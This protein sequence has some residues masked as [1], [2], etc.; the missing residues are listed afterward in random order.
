M[1]VAMQAAFAA[2]VWS[3]IGLAMVL[4]F[5]AIA[6]IRRGGPPF[7]GMRCAV[8]MA[9]F[10]PVA[11][12][13]VCVMVP[14]ANSDNANFAQAL[15]LVLLAPLNLAFFVWRYRAACTPPFAR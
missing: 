1:P 12:F 11:I 8:F 6:R 5:R 13:D 9:W 3:V 14:L 7:P 4:G 15:G 10:V 2:G